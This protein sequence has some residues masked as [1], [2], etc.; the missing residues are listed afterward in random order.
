RDE[1]PETAPRASENYP[2]EI[3]KHPE[4]AGA[5]VLAPEI[6]R[7]G[8]GPLAEREQCIDRDAEGSPCPRQA[9]DC[10]CHDDRRNC[11]TNGH[12]QTPEEDPEQIEKNRHHGHASLEERSQTHDRTI[13][14]T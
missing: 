14:Y 5:D 11:P 9:D 13:S 4:R 3:A 10:D 2:H 7:A 6:L 8:N 1:V 12:P